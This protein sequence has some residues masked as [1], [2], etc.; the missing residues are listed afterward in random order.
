MSNSISGVTDSHWVR[1]S[2]APVNELPEESLRYLDLSSNTFGD[3][4][5]TVILDALVGCTY[6]SS[7]NLYVNYWD[8]SV[9]VSIT[10]G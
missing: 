7:V 5:D 10:A 1:E 9:E 3:M 8:T 4:E 2:S 6:L